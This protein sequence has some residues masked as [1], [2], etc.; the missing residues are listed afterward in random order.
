MKN[1]KTRKGDES[2]LNNKESLSE[3]ANYLSLVPSVVGKKL[4][5]HNPILM[6]LDFNFSTWSFLCFYNLFGNADYLASYRL[7]K[8]IEQFRDDA[9][10]ITK[11]GGPSAL[12]DVELVEAVQWRALVHPSCGLETITREEPLSPN[13]RQFLERRLN[14]WMEVSEGVRGVKEEI[15]ALLCYPALTYNPDEKSYPK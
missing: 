11:M 10:I 12:N 15:V 1:V 9:A 8:L 4:R 7:D 5:I 2:L 13:L 3:S 14:Q 6:L